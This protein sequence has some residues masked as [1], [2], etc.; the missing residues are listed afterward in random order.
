MFVTSIRIPDLEQSIHVH[1]SL[2]S[3]YMRSMVG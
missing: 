2:H 1:D 3:M